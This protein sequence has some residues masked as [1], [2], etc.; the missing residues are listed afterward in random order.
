MEISQQLKE[1]KTYI[2]LQVLLL[3]TKCEEG[4]Q[5]PLTPEDYLMTCARI[6][7][8]HIVIRES[9]LSRGWKEK[10]HDALVAF[11]K[12]AEHFNFD[13]PR[14][15]ARIKIPV[16]VVDKVRD[17]VKA[18]EKAAVD[19][20]SHRLAVLFGEQCDAMFG[21]DVPGALGKPRA[22]QNAVDTAVNSISQKAVQ[23][24]MGKPAKH[25]QASLATLAVMS[26]FGPKF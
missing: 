22:A 25:T 1:I 11:R 14:P 7:F 23:Q 10:S 3:M 24:I 19:T 8:M 12:V 9:H 15:D 6:V 16:T 4:S 17:Q 18:F 20:P 21:G 2:P 13:N 26:A 5:D